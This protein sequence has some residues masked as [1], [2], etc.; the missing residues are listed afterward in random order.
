MEFS[1]FVRTGSDEI[2]L[3]V[4]LKKACQVSDFY[5]IGNAGAEI[6]NR[7]KSSGHGLPV[8]DVQPT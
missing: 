7:F 3:F 1:D 5:A 2:A 6:S 8:S 4:R